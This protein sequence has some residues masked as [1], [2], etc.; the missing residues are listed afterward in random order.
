MSPR[1]AIFISA[2]SSEH[3]I[4]HETSAFVLLK[5]ETEDFSKGIKLLEEA[6]QRDPKFAL[7]FCLIAKAHDF[8]YF[9]GLDHT[10]ERRTLGDAAVNEALRLRPELSE[11]H[12]AVA[13][14]LY[15][16]YRDFERARVQIAMAARGLLNNPELLELTA[17]IDRTQ[18]RWEKSTSG[19]EKAATSDPRNPEVLELLIENYFAL[20]R[21]KDLEQIQDKLKDIVT[22]DLFT[23]YKADYAFH[24]KAD[25]KGARAG[26]EALPSSMK[27]DPWFTA[28][29]FYYAMCDRD[30]KSA[31]E[32][33]SKS[34]SK[35]IG[36][37]GA[38]VPRRVAEM[39][40]EMAHGNHPRM[41]GVR[42]NA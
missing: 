26:Y 9:D 20:R 14:H 13:L 11:V 10:P 25:V 38:V 3:L 23:M 7:G 40:L 34:P 21:Y 39:W 42:C 33:I 5:N 2:V 22:P 4:V 18:G 37:S 29:R 36:F 41:Q 24:V 16:C 30:W 27:D 12:L 1:P 8:L 19:L 32:I 35:E 6:T 28:T 31:G 15:T 17:L